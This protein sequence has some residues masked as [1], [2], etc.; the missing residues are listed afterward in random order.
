M[1]V[2]TT[3]TA[4]KMLLFQTSLLLCN[5]VQFVK[6]WQIF[7]ELS[8]KGLYPSLEVE[9]KIVTLCSYAL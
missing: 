6:C 7:L 9:K 8:S 2:S 3:V 1:L 4:A 5:C